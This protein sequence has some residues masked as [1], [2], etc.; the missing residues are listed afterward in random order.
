MFEASSYYPC[1]KPFDE[2]FW[3]KNERSEIKFNRR[4]HKKKYRK[5]TLII[6]AK[7]QD[8]IVLVGDR[9]VSGSERYAN[10]IRML[11]Q[12]PI[13]FTAG[14]IEPLFEE[15]LE[16]VEKAALWKYNWIQE[17]NKNQPESLHQVFT[18]TDFKH[19]CVETL[20]RM[21]AI[22]TELEQSTSFEYALQVFFVLP[23]QRNGQDDV[24]LYKMNMED[25]FPNPVEAGKVSAIG[26]HYLGKPFL[27]SLE[28][29]NET[30]FMKDVAR[31]ASFVIK[32]IEI[33][34]LD[35]NNGIGVG[36]FDP[37]IW[38]VTPKQARE[39][40]QDELSE[41]LK[42]VEDEIKKFRET[43]GSES[44]FLRS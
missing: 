13:V 1:K 4:L 27:K 10:K 12:L 31:V 8:G 2:Y 15:F 43:I 38:Y 26:N 14:G 34:K 37:Q 20:K 17:E 36:D 41:L 23:E 7:C 19:T 5:M 25:C 22:Y 42:G 29:K 18:A 40:P 30:L 39:I 44:S 9:K 11:E 32:Y 21:K 33:E 35:S 6:A 16:Q 24:T 3:A 28:N